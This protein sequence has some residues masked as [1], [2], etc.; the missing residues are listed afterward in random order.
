MTLITDMAP[1]RIVEH[2]GDLYMIEEVEVEV[3]MQKLESHADYIKALYTGSE[4]Y[5]GHYTPSPPMF[6]RL[7]GVMG[8]GTL[9]PDRFKLVYKEEEL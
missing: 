8:Q 3:T 7:R 4:D 6:T 2:D 5:A 9:A 1:G